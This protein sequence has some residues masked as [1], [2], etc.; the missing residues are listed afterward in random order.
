MERRSL[1]VLNVNFIGV[2]DVTSWSQERELR[3][4]ILNVFRAYNKPQCCF[5]C[6]WTGRHWAMWSLQAHYYMFSQTW[7]C[8]QTNAFSSCM[9]CSGCPFMTV[10][11]VH[12][13]ELAKSLCTHIN[14]NHTQCYTSVYLYSSCI[15]HTCNGSVSLSWNS[16]HIATLDFRNQELTLVL[17][18]IGPVIRHWQDYW[19]SLFRCH[20]VPHPLVPPSPKRV[21]YLFL[22]LVV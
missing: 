8:I 1:C 10:L 4:P 6:S 15:C 18:L 13:Q 3:N 5:S 17:L 20:M 11:Q 19:P 14:K 12:S 16:S 7:K 2:I 22:R 21:T 9:A